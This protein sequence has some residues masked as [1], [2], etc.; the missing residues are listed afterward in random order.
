M[1]ERRWQG[2][3]AFSGIIFAI[4]CGAGLEVASPQP[5]NFAMSAAATARYYVDHRTGLLWMVTLCGIS[6]AFLLAWTI[7]LGLTFWRRSEL[8]R[9][10]T[11]VA[12]VSLAASPIL[13]SF[14][15]TFFA[16][17]AYRA[18]SANAD[19][20]QALSD[21]A[22][23]G[24]MLIWPQL[25]AAMALVG[26]LILKVRGADILPRWLGWFSVFCAAVE[27]F[28]LGIIFTK[29]GAF[30]PRGWTTWYGAVLTWGV[31]V[32][33]LSVVMCRQ[34]WAAEASPAGVRRGVLAA[35]A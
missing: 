17:A 11:L 28:Q 23:I 16:I 13:L 29:H 22:W 27:P 32:L 34:L 14:D 4:L 35:G 15:L 1:N 2:L 26:V 33:A 3:F 30:G 7:Q 18:G 24:S 25:A 10:V 21:I 20:T 5:P 19:V 31:W 8:S 12:A 6:V 9:T